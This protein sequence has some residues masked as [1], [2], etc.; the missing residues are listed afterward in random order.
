MTT[1]AAPHR[2]S[3]ADL[4]ANSPAHRRAQ[5][6][7]ADMLAPAQLEPSARFRVEFGRAIR[8][9]GMTPHSRLVALTLSTFANYRTGHIAAQQQPG[10]H[11]LAQATGLTAGQVVVALRA[12]E[13]RGWV[14]RTG[15][16]AYE[17]AELR[18]HIPQHAVASLR[19]H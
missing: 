3:P 13:S 19:H 10:L 15:S 2:P 8:A 11:G 12:L 6:R 4:A 16:R 5:S 14:S 17:D 7:L 9:S 1:A 18:P